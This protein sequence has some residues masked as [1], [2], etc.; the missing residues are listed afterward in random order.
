MDQNKDIYSK[1]R[2]LRRARGFTVNKLAEKMGENH[3]KVGRIERGMRSITIDYLM[4][5]SKALDTPIEA[6]LEKGQDKELLGGGSE[7]PN[8]NTLLN[9]VVIRVEKCPCQFSAEQKGTL[10]AKVFAL[11]SKFPREHQE[12]FLEAF[13]EGLAVLEP[14]N[15]T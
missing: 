9:Q 7:A 5:V 4:K 10:V 6:L 15:A 8:A 12:A 14:M 2:N 13:F 3:Q 1:L 11:A